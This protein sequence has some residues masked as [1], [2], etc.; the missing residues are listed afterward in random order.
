MGQFL[1]HILLGLAVGVIAS[2]GVATAQTGTVWP[3]KAPEK[4]GLAILDVETTGLQPGHHEM[5]D[6]GLIY[7][8]LDG[9][10]I[11][12]FYTRILPD[13]PERASEGAVAV[14]AFSVD[15]WEAL[16]AVSEAEAVDLLL[17]FHEAHRGDRI[18][19]MT[20]FNSWF[21]AAFLQ[22]FLAE[23]GYNARD[24]YHYHVLDIPSMAWGDGAMGVTSSVL[25]ANYGLPDE[26]RVP[27]EHTGA[28]GAAFNLAL[29]QAI[30]KRR[31][32]KGAD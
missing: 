8:D 26:T 4:W 28:T 31:N 1:K 18:W 11:A 22:A 21:D 7:T 27:E 12:R 10:E 20:A 30:V 25:A 2:A 13:F 24:L 32:A 3:D 6:I 15:R 5:I 29:Y 16:G 9:N 23:E 14:N 17:A 19:M